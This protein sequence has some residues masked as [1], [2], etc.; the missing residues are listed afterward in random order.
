MAK[1]RSFTKEEIEDGTR[2]A[3]DMHEGAHKSGKEKKYDAYLEWKKQMKKKHGF[4]NV[5]YN[6][7]TFEPTGSKKFPLRL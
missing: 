3:R 6:V 7:N 1:S 4:M 5:T 2:L